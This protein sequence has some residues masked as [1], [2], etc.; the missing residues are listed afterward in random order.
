[1]VAQRLS[2]ILHE[3]G[4][5]L[6]KSLH[7]L[8]QFTEFLLNLVNF[9]RRKM[10]LDWGNMLDEWDG[11]NYWERLAWENCSGPREI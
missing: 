10:V 7:A 11:E 3:S 4:L 1:M 2:L 5:G 9:G 6:H 8:L